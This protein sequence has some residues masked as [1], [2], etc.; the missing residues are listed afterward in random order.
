MLAAA[1]TD[2]KCASEEAHGR[3]GEDDGQWDFGGAVT[4][5]FTAVIAVRLDKEGL[6][7]QVGRGEVV[8]IVADVEDALCRRSAPTGRTARALAELNRIRQG[9]HRVAADAKRTVGVGQD[10]GIDGV[11]VTG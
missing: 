9:V 11:A 1:A 4:R 10:A 3:E 7:P 8:L 6:R 2:Q 5:V